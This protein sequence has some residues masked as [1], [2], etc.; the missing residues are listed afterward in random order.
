MTTEPEPPEPTRRG[1]G[2]G[3]ISGTAWTAL[4]V[5]VSVPIAFLVNVLVARSLGVVD[6]GR[7][8]ILTMVLA[9]ATAA[10]SSGVGAALMQFVTKASEAGRHREV[11]RL[12]SGAQGYNLMIAAPVVAVIVALVVDVSWPFVVL[13]VVFGV[14]GPALLQVGPVL[15][16]SQ[17]RSDRSAQLAMVSN[18][19]IQAAV[20][21]SVL[22]HPT[23]GAVWASRVAAT[24]ALM[25]LPFLALSRSLRRAAL[26]PSWPWSLPRTFW[27]FAV[28]TGL[29]TLLSQIVT[30]RVQVFVLEWFADQSAVGLFALAFGLAAQILA[31]VQAAVGPMLP[32]FA[33]LRHRGAAEARD[34]LLRV[35]RV[36]S[37]ITGSVLSVGVPA[38]AGLIPW[39]Y[40]QEYA[41]SAHYFVV[42]AFAA[43]VAVV[44]SGAYASLM[45]RLRGASYLLINGAALVIMLIL[46]VV[47]I[48]LLGAWGAVVSM[49]GGTSVRALSMVVLEVR[50]H[51]V[52]S[53]QM[54]TS[55]LPMIVATMCTVLVW[56]VVVRFVQAPEWLSGV[57]GC[58]LSFGLFAL[59]LRVTH[60]GLEL[61]DREALLSV[62]PLGSRP[63]VNG[64]LKLVSRSQPQDMC[65]E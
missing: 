54:A 34:G 39:I 38:L 41:S 46:A 33:V 10:A 14:F 24:G 57:I 17:H 29:A 58:A 16:A 9:L 50:H 40:G 19:L 1:V 48:P 52:A 42:M 53:A 18:V 32:A 15:L 47:A 64:G 60:C 6:Y 55:L 62:V 36:A 28:P 3:L 51:R 5:V 37:V 12:V 27:A 26:H 22:V 20:V 7:L 11:S 44:G 30:D 8:A 21:T 23:A 2:E 56:F 59:V 65:S 61:R 49:V 35:T 25:V 31:P 13:A 45:A 63:L 4:H 43:G